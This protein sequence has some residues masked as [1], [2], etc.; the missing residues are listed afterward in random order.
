MHSVSTLWQEMIENPLVCKNEKVIIAGTE[1]GVSQLVGGT[2]SEECMDATFE[3]GT[4]VARELQVK[5]FPTA[6]IPRMAKIERY[7]QLVLKD[8]SGVVTSESEWVPKGTF[9]I[10]TRVKSPQGMYTLTAYDSMLKT[11]TR[12]WDSSSGT[13]DWPMPMASAV[14]DIASKIGI[15]VDNRTV[16]NAT[17]TVDYPNDRT[18]REVLCDIAAAHGG[19]WVITDANKLRLITFATIDT[20]ATSG[21]VN[22]GSKVG[23]FE[24]SDA[25]EPITRVTLYWDDENAFTSPVNP[26]DA[27]DTGREIVADCL[28]ATQAMADN[29]LAQLKGFQYQPYTSNKAWL[30][31]AYEIGDVV[32]IRNMWSYLTNVSSN[33]ST[34]VMCSVSAPYEQEVDHEFPYV[35]TVSRN[36]KRKVAL[37]QSYYGVSISRDKGIQIQKTNGETVQGEALFNSDVLSMKAMV[38]G[39]MKDCIYFDAVEGK[40]K[41][42]GDVLIEGAVQSDASITDALYAEQGDISQLTVDRLETSDKIKRYLSKD[43]SQMSFIRIEGLKLQFIIATLSVDENGNPKTEPL[44]N[45]YGLPLYWKKDISNA[46]IVNG[47]PYIDGERVYTTEEDTGFPVLVYSYSEAIVRQ[48]VFQYDTIT[49]F[50]FCNETFGQGSGVSETTGKT[51]NQGYMQKSDTSFFM[52]YRTSNGKEIGIQM[53]NDGYTDLYGLRRTTDLNFSEWDNGVFYERISGDS[54]RYAYSVKFNAEG[55]P[56]SITD[57]DGNVCTVEL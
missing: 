38:D 7:V 48:I 54:E 13:G 49:G 56:I 20:N 9:Y 25:F 23:H 55:D 57:A 45:R 29:L 3:I 4:A 26:D 27:S 37:G 10:D 47:Y 35:G 53:N 43:K 21:Y 30:D 1:Y 2:V 33:I 19:V 39:A 42:S 8:A 24:S 11:D 16:I 32:H 34:G 28:C 18:M 15:E 44:K 52:K 41:I 22:I 50:Y 5:L 17:Y 12:W 31:P 51:H 40:Y 46:E 6:S 36:L 14:A